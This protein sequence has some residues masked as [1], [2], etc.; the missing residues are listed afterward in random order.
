MSIELLVALLSLA[1]AVTC[2]L[3]IVALQSRMSELR[4]SL[5]V[6]S[7]SMGAAAA[8]Q[9]SAMFRGSRPAVVLIVQEWCES[10][11]AVASWLDSDSELADFAERWLVSA[12]ELAKP[13]TDLRYVVD[14]ELV[15]L[16][17]AQGCPTAVHFNADGEETGRRLIGSETS[18]QEFRA[19]VLGSSKE[20]HNVNT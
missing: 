1:L 14:G 15:A 18:Y 11:V 6:P 19:L 17:L 5:I 12:T 2:L 10:C 9:L 13:P 3:M 8:S 4:K 20:Q 16:F 7:W